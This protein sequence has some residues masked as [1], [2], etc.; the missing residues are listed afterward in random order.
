MLDLRPPQ[1]STASMLYQPRL[2]RCL[3]KAVLLNMSVYQYCENI[4]RSTSQPQVLLCSDTNSCLYLQIYH[5]GVSNMIL[6]CSDCPENVNS[7]YVNTVVQS[8][9]SFQFFSPSVQKH[10]TPLYFTTC[11]H[12]TCCKWRSN[13]NIT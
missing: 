2:R 4:F 11:L 8:D 6:R 7:R 1:H 9:G 5:L 12:H 13:S 10:R 3:M